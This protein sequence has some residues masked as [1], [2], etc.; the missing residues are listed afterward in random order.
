MSK[1]YIKSTEV[2]V[3]IRRDL[4]NKY[5]GFKFSVKTEKYSG[6][7]TIKVAWEDGP[8][9]TEVQELLFKYASVR[10]SLR[11]DDS[12]DYVRHWLVGGDIVASDTEPAPGAEPVMLGSSHVICNRHISYDFTME[13]LKAAGI[14]KL[15]YDSMHGLSVPEYR[16]L[17]DEIG[18]TSGYVA[19]AAPAQPA[20]AATKQADGNVTITVQGTWTWVKFAQKPEQTILDLLSGMGARFS[21]KRVAWYFTKVVDA[22]ELSFI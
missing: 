19:P 7:A 11:M 14:S 2:A 3:L 20:Q 16:R 13:C 8:T 12:V 1:R 10:T 9:S 5:P 6:G 18:K 21:K 15:A 4:A 22:S 17:Q